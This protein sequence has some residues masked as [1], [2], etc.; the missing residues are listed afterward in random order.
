MNRADSLHAL[1]QAALG[2]RDQALATLHS[3]QS[4]L[5]HAQAQALVL[6]QYSA[7]YMQRWN[8]QFRSGSAIELLRCYQSFMHRLDQALSHQQ[9]QVQGAQQHADAARALLRQRQ[10]QL[11]SIEKLIER[12]RAEAA[13]IA[14]RNEQRASDEA[15]QR[16]GLRA[17]PR[18]ANRTEVNPW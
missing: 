8:T 16:M 3:L 10:L 7:Q 15:A 4:R 14:A 6:R 5:E 13:Q 12:R 9:A 17:G 11:A 2:E 1:Q 18:G